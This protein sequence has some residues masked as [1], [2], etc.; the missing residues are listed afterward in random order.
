MQALR[1]NTEVDAEGHFNLPRLEIP[2]G[3]AVEVIVLVPDNSEE[4]ES[5]AAASVSSMDFW[6]NPIDDEVWNNA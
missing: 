4:I 3:T 5:L 6:D 2:A 1:Y